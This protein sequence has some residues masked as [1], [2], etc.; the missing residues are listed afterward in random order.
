MMTL[1]DIEIEIDATKQIGWRAKLS[2][3]AKKMALDAMMSKLKKQRE[4][5]KEIPDVNGDEII[6]AFINGNR[7][8]SDKEYDAVVKKFGTKGLT[9]ID[10]MSS[11]SIPQKQWIFKQVGWNINEVE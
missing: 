10:G 6:K 8:L 4:L 7:K 11:L 3:K 5:L 9:M 2:A 1:E